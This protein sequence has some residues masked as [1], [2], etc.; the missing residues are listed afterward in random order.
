MFLAGFLQRYHLSW[1]IFCSFEY[2]YFSG[3]RFHLIRHLSWF[4]AHVTLWSF[5]L[6]QCQW[7]PGI[8]NSLGPIDIILWHRSESTLAQ[9]MARCLMS[10]SHYLNQFDLS[11]VR[12]VAAT[13][14][15]KITYWKILLHLP[16]ANELISTLSWFTAHVTLWCF[17]LCLCQSWPGILYES[18]RG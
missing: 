9:V 6:C 5:P 17:P 10:P 13:K 3:F 12:P 14:C 11:L 16:G 2:L 7:W 8:L 1:F 18:Q 4:M 15:L